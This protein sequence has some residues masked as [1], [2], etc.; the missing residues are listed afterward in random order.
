MSSAK[1]KSKNT[2]AKNN[3]KNLEKTYQKM[4]QHEHILKKPGM[5]I[6]SVKKEEGKMWIYDD[7]Q[8]ENEPAIVEKEIKFVPALYKI[9][10]E[11]IVNARDHYIRTRKE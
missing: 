9:Y 2:G 5:Y 8:K 11:I 4:D 6:G 1:G 7:K 3:D 10:D